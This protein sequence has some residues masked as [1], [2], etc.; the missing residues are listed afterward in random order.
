MHPLQTY[1]RNLQIAAL[2]STEYHEK[3]DYLA[4]TIGVS[5]G[6]LIRLHH[7]D[8]SKLIPAKALRLELATNGLVPAA[9]VCHGFD[10]IILLLGK[11]ERMR[12]NNR[13]AAAISQ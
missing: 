13:A 3:L 5:A 2:T 1:L 9:S 7:P 6:F 12:E 10:E 8:Q 11:V 4:A